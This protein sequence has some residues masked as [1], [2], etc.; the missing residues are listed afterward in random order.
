MDN[1]TKKIENFDSCLKKEL[2]KLCLNFEN[3]GI[4]NNKY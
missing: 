1:M 2:F 4:I 3:D